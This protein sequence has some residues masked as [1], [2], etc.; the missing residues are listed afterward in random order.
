MSATAPRFLWRSVR[1]R[2]LKAR[3]E[4]I[5][6]P[7]LRILFSH[8]RVETRVAILAKWLKFRTT[9]RV[10]PI[11]PSGAL[12]ADP[13]DVSDAP[14]SDPLA[15]TSK[16]SAG[17]GG[18]NAAAHGA[19]LPPSE[20]EASPEELE[21]VERVWII[22]ELIYYL[23]ETAWLAEFP[24]HAIR[25]SLLV[26]LET[27]QALCRN[28][29]ADMDLELAYFRRLLF[30][31]M[32]A[33]PPSYLPLLSREQGK[34]VY[35]HV[36]SAYFRQYHLYKHIFSHGPMTPPALLGPPNS[37][38]ASLDTGLA[39]PAAELHFATVEPTVHEE[40]VESVG[41]ELPSASAAA[42]KGSGEGGG[43]MASSDEAG[44]VILSPSLLQELE[45]GANLEQVSEQLAKLR[46]EWN[47]KLDVV[48]QLISSKKATTAAGG[49]AK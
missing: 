5:S 27:H 44:T 30:S 40:Q 3:V 2:N 15:S 39:P 11:L 14:P 4:S 12:Q 6:E 35:Q 24:I 33:Q 23:I 36:L 37:V 7:Q 45:Q 22:T 8:P 19:A 20:P 16:L 41:Q 34:L 1:D 46:L 10:V 42:N 32:V 26:F 43:M 47:T 9:P 31:T 28:P 13:E 25:A 29:I 49:P 18:S 21:R 38:H 17:Q 48:Q